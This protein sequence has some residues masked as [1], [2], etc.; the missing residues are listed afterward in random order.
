VTFFKMPPWTDHTG[1]TAER[2][3]VRGAVDAQN[4]FGVRIRSWWEI[5]VLGFEDQFF[6]GEVRLDGEVV[7]QLDGYRAMLHDRNAVR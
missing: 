5:V 3:L 6:P 4:S 2:W 1:A 7:F